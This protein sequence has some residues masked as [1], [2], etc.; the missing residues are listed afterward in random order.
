LKKDE[1]GYPPDRWERMWAFKTEPGRY[2]ID[3]IPFFVR[4]IS[5]GDVVS[6]EW[7][8]DR[9]MFKELVRPS[10][11]S[12]FRL[13][14]YDAGAVQSVRDRFRAIGCASELSHLP[15]LIAVEVP[16]TINFETV[17][18][19][20]EGASKKVAGILRREYF[21]IKRCHELPRRLTF[22]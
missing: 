5:S 17:A 4:G 9:L 8:G 19:L 14:I 11:N 1:D 21:A 16:G 12:V 20:L 22:Q 10:L 3:N 15:K 18:K 7:D 13:I 6:A 2:T